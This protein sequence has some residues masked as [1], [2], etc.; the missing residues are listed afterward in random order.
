MSSSVQYLNI[1]FCIGR[2][3][4]HVG[5]IVEKNKLVFIFLLNSDLT[6]KAQTLHEAYSRFKRALQLTSSQFTAF[7]NAISL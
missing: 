7:T 1:I 6:L 5:A 4:L 3:L 2:D